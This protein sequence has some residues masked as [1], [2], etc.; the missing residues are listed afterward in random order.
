LSDPLP[1]P[2][3]GPAP[4][5]AAARRPWLILFLVL[6]LC[7]VLVLLYHLRAIF[8]PLLVAL[9][10]AYILNPVVNACEKRRV[11]RVAAILVLYVIF[12]GGV[13]LA[14]ILGI[15]PLVHQ[16]VQLFED[17]FVGEPLTEDRNQNGV[18]DE[19]DK[20]DDANRNQRWDPPKIT[21]LLEWSQG[22]LKELTGSDDIKAH[23]RRLREKVSGREG[24]V[25]QAAGRAGG[26][27]LHGVSA[28][29]GGLLTLLGF[30][31][32]VPVY[33]F[34]M[35]K[36][37]NAIW[38]WTRGAIPGAYRERV[39]ATLLRIDKANASFFRGQVTIA[40]I[41]AVILA[42][43]LTALGVKF[44][45]L[46]AVL[47]ACAAMIPYVGVAFMFASIQL[48][49]FVDQ[50]GVGTTFWLVAGL[51]LFIQVLEGLV[52]Q[53]FILG[54]ETGLHPVAIMVSI[55][56]FGELFGFFGLLLAIPLASATIIV[57]KDYLVPVVREVTEERVG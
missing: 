18:W 35:L 13:A 33:M 56:I 26:A 10:L 5:A 4:P 38:E 27:I 48:V 36:N 47:Y 29:V 9:G 8:T 45:L 21:R 14:A 11:P 7:G 16:G 1:P 44:S 17:L 50:G 22:R 37:M 46:F 25:A 20:Y 57:V 54:K 39:V 52:L 51:F 53:P 30:V 28:S 24:D 55:F 12:F 34:F 31:V 6:L 40:L 2:A 19:G 42:V 23:L 41:E 43:V 32:L 49:V 15:P 3:G